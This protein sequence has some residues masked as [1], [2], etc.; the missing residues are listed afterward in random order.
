[1]FKNIIIFFSFTLL[2]NCSGPGT[3]FL[4]PTFTGVKTGSVY[5]T[6]LSY[7]S[8][9][10]MSVTRDVFDINNELSLV[11]SN[12]VVQFESDKKQL[13]ILSAL[14]THA[15]EISETTIEEPLP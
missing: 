13:P 10:V 14:K 12:E 11:K 4:G 3:A 2:L 15:I 9:K 8:G 7:G 6:S 5:Q 1:M